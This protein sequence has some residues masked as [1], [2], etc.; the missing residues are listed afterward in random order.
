MV[1]LGIYLILLSQ[2]EWPRLRDP[3]VY[4]ADD[5][6]ELEP[7]DYHHL[8][9]SLHNQRGQSLLATSTNNTYYALGLKD[10]CR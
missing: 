7:F 3:S 6:S 5:A 8:K 4:P 9:P 2:I 1:V 10:M